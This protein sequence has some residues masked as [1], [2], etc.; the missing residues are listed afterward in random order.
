MEFILQENEEFNAEIQTVAMLLL[1]THKMGAKVVLSSSFY[2]FSLIQAVS[3]TLAL[4][5]YG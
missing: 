3:L 4:V 5:H 1:R 2:F